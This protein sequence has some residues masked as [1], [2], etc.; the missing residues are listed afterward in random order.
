MTS[1]AEKVEVA[2][3]ACGA[4]FSTW[5]RPSI[6]LGLGEEWSPEELEE[7]TTATCPECGHREPLGSLIVSTRR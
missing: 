5:Y 6:N 4:R 7:A 1:P 3:P 2:C